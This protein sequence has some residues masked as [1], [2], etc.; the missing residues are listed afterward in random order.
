MNF[1]HKTCEW[2]G[3]SML[4]RLVFVCGDSQWS[5]E[6]LNGVRANCWGFEKGSLQMVLIGGWFWPIRMLSEV[7]PVKG[8]QSRVLHPPVSNIREKI[9]FLISNIWKFQLTLFHLMLLSL[10]YPSFN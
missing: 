10:K 2:W 6:Q 7:S 9:I 1:Y 4:K 3:Q 8:Q 5:Q